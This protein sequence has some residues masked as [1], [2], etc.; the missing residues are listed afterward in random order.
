VYRKRIAASFQIGVVQHLHSVFT[1]I[2][3]NRTHV[4]VALAGE[5]GTHNALQK[6]MRKLSTYHRD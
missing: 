4:T 2:A 3:A 5:H 6:S 1:D